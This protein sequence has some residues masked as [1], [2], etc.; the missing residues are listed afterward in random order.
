MI[1]RQSNFIEIFFYFLCLSPDT[2]WFIPIPLFGLKIYSIDFLI[3]FIDYS[4]IL[5]ALQTYKLTSNP[6]L[7]CPQQKPGKLIGTV[8][9]FHS[10]KESNRTQKLICFIQHVYFR[11]LQNTFSHDMIVDLQ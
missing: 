8:R 10:S 1:T 3:S 2:D 9:Y 6:F 7:L 5:I 11:S 4:V